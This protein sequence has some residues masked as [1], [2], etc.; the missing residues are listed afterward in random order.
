MAQVLTDKDIFARLRRDPDFIKGFPTD[1]RD[2]P[3][4]DIGDDSIWIAKE[5]PVQPCSVDLHVGEVFV[6]AAEPGAQGS[7][8]QGI[9]Q[10]D[11]EPGHTAVIATL[12]E[13]KLPS[14]IGALGSPPTRVS[15]NHGLLMVNPGHID[16][17]F[18][19]KLRLIVINMGRKPVRLKRNQ[20]I[21]TL[22]FFE[23]SAQPRR[24]Y[25]ART[26]GPVVRQTV[27][28]Q[29]SPDF[30][31]VE[32][33]AQTIADRTAQ[34]QVD[35]NNDELNAAIDNSKRTV[36]SAV[37]DA[38]TAANSLRNWQ[39]LLSGLAAVIVAAIVGFGSYSAYSGI[40]ALSERITKVEEGV[41]SASIVKSLESFE[42]RIVALES[43]IQN[44]GN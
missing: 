6:P 3:S 31:N 42:E 1:W 13:L 10:L 43:S 28:D 40:A 41:K 30:L 23:L 5:S 27:L 4:E 44:Q 7:E 26:Q 8:G 12:E 25:L 29:L 36:E 21:V 22:V 16:P 32:E 33:R 39:S 18:A 38:K 15:F 35:R 20:P 37:A 2:K 11:L 19:G 9:D 24:T 14:T 17:G 34:I